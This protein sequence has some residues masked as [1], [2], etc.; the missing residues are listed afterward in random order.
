MLLYKK[1]VIVLKKIYAIDF[2]GTL[3]LDAF[4]SIGKPRTR[5]ILY[6]KSLQEN[7]HKLILW[8]CRSGLPLENAIKWCASHGLIFDAI[9][10]NVE[11]TILKY[12]TDSR[13]VTAD[14]YIDDR[15]MSFFR[16]YT[17]TIFSMGGEKHGTNRQHTDSTDFQLFYTR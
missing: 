2:D 1:G 13:K 15:F 14:Y 16:I 10:N 17:A 12:G 7:G 6:A 4:P 5:M 8:T 3:C 9:N 11:E